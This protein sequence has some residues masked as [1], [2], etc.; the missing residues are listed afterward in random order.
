M[1]AL[2]SEF[3]WS[4]EHERVFFKLLESRKQFAHLVV[5]RDA[6]QSQISDDFTDEEKT[7]VRDI[8]NIIKRVNELMQ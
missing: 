4:S 1:N 2:Q 7:H 6:V 3:S 5:D 8:V